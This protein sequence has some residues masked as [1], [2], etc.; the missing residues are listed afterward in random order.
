MPMW[1]VRDEFRNE[2][3]WGTAS[4]SNLLERSQLNL[5][6]ATD[7][8]LGRAEFA[9]DPFEKTIGR[10]SQ[11]GL[12]NLAWVIQQTPS[13]VP[14]WNGETYSILLWTAVPRFIWPDKP[15]ATLGQD[16]G[17]R[18]NLLDP[19]DLGTS[20]NMGQLIEMYANFGVTA[21]VVGMFLLGLIYRLMYELFGTRPDCEGTLL[22][23]IV[24]FSNL[25][26]GIDYDT[27]VVF[28]N[29]VITLVALVIF[30]RVIGFDPLRKFVQR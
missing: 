19:T 23:G 27:Q 12:L 9:Q 17:H 18:Y 20:Y 6:L 26:G 29:F 7:Y 21:V 3:W 15:R 8:V 4:S 5:S 25:I 22:I 1:A 30:V 2:T 10:T 14:F 24:I 16:F 11:H 28:G 13:I